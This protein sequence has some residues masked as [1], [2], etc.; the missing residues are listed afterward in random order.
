M[1]QGKSLQ[2]LGEDQL[3]SPQAG[4]D[5]RASLITD[6]PD[7]SRRVHYKHTACLLQ[8][9]RS[10]MMRV[11]VNS[12]TLITLTSFEQLRVRDEGTLNLPCA[13]PIIVYIYWECELRFSVILPR[14]RPLPPD[15]LGLEPCVRPSHSPLLLSIVQPLVQPLFWFGTA[16]MRSPSAAREVMPALNLLPLLKVSTEHSTAVSEKRGPVKVI[17]VLDWLVAISRQK[18]G[19]LHRGQVVEHDLVSATIQIISAESAQQHTSPDATVTVPETIAQAGVDCDSNSQE[20]TTA[21][22]K[23]TA[24]ANHRQQ[25][26]KQQIHCLGTATV[27]DTSDSPELMHKRWEGVQSGVCACIS[28][29]LFIIGKAFL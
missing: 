25:N 7:V 18:T 14:R 2:H 8:P 28:G 13:H 19:A 9:R 15:G 17:Q 11:R 26:S 23:H 3:R 20:Q 4:S 12:V 29:Q 21:Y 16:L 1:N 10:R 27:Q 22:N 24:L 5:S 6:R